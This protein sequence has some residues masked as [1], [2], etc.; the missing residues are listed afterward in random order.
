[1]AELMTEAECEEILNPWIDL[2]DSHLADA[3]VPIQHRPLAVAVDLLKVKAVRV[4]M[5]GIPQSIDI[6][7]ADSP[8]GKAWFRH[9]YQKV[10][11]WYRS[12]YGSAM[13]M[14]ESSLLGVIQFRRTS[15]LVRVPTC[16]RRPAE[17]KRQV[18]VS[19]PDHVRSDERALSW[20]VTPPNVDALDADQRSALTAA[21]H[22]LAADLR[23]IRSRLL[24]THPSS[25]Q[26]EGFASGAVKHLQAFAELVM[27]GDRISTLKS[28]WELQM[29]V[30]SVVKGLVLQKTG[31]F[32]WIHTVPELLAR[33]R[34]VGLDFDEARFATWPDKDEIGN[35]RYG[36][37]TRDRT[38]DAHA[39]YRLTVDLCREAAKLY[40]R[41]ADIGK[42]SFLIQPVPWMV[43]PEPDR[44]SPAA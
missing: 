34:A 27:A 26:L 28:W 19:F 7:G 22:G 6:D 14:E 1:M 2:I 24:S 40:E 23:F 31:S 42:A 29:A 11:R 8:L 37:G 39:A 5:G 30:E 43:E 9:L 10:D 4:E 20:L 33:A 15:I 3:D 13:T 44:G 35:L 12:T 38:T 18:W 16:V 41:K 17:D 36:E 25:P 21:V 32:P